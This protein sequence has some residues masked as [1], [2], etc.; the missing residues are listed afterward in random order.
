MRSL[1]P[2]LFASLTLLACSGSNAGYPGATACVDLQGCCSAGSF[3]GNGRAG[4]Q[5]LVQADDDTAC[6][7]ALGSYVSAGACAA[8]E[9]VSG[10]QVTN[11]SCSFEP[12]LYRV[13]FIASGSGTNCPTPSDTTV[14][15][16]SDNPV[17]MAGDAGLTCTTTSAGCS[18][19]SSCAGD[20]S[21]YRTTAVISV[22]ES[23]GA[24]TG[25]ETVSAI[26]DG[27]GMVLIACTF[28]FTYTKQ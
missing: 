16:T 27:T 17:P 21:G 5:A 18:F 6:A 19:T 28:D 22:D 2:I 3:P 9:P 11:G 14:T 7:Q 12:G 20:P 25:T 13:H 24:I 1:A 8:S 26:M 15:V 23:A 10:P 4:C